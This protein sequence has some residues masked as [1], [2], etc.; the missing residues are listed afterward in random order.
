MGRNKKNSTRSSF[1]KEVLGMSFKMLML[2]YFLAC[3]ITAEEAGDLVL[4]D[5]N[6]YHQGKR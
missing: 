1:L 5:E 2:H 4:E 3:K 6:A